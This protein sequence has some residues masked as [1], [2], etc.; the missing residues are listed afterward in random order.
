[1][2]S[3][4]R[5]L[6]YGNF[7][8]KSVSFSNRRQSLHIPSVRIHSII[9]SNC[10][11]GNCQIIIKDQFWIN[12]QPRPQTRT[13]RT[14]PLRRV[15]AKQSRLQLWNIDIRMINTSVS[16]RK[17]LHFIIIRIQNLDNS[18]TQIQR[19]LNALAQSRSHFRH[20]RQ[21][22]NNQL[23]VMLVTFL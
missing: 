19:L 7:Q 4:I 18:L 22:I 14:S 16:L 21:P 10:A 11:F 9:R 1:M 12:L 3:I 6:A 20:Q 15:K 23:D 5:K 2:L 8:A 17:C 13:H